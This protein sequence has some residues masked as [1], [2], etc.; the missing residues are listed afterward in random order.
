MERFKKEH[1]RLWATLIENKNLDILI[2]SII[3]NKLILW[4]LLIQKTLKVILKSGV[5]YKYLNSES[6]STAG[7]SY[8]YILSFKMS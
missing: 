6:L 2:R 3:L 8:L 1:D 4:Y 5:N 7:N